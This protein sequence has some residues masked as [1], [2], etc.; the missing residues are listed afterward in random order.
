M[1]PRIPA[2][3]ERDITRQVCD[4][5]KYRGWRLLR[6]NVTKLPIKGQ[7]V[8]F[9]EEGIPDYSAIYY[10]R[11]HA[12]LV[13]WLEFKRQ[14]G[15]RLGDAQHAWAEKEGRLGAT[16]LKINNFRE[17]EQF[18]RDQFEHAASPIRQRS[19]LADC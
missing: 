19:L 5:L 8:S 14:K 16:V 3:L 13:I 7:W 2:L 18:Y 6:H 12:A 1:N 9:G 10:L 11:N 15:G 17:F 4:F